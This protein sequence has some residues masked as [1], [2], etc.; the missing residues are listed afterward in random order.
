VP[1]PNDGEEAGEQDQSCADR[2]DHRPA[3]EPDVV[4]GRRGEPGDPYGGAVHGGVGINRDADDPRQDPQAGE[5]EERADDNPAESPGG[6]DSDH[7]SH[8]E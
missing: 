2:G 7:A 5:C 6:E 3:D 4:D 1:A 8:R